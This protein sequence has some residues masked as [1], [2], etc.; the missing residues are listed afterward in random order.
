MEN[1][2]EKRLASAGEV[3]QRLN[4]WTQS[5]TLLPATTIAKSA[6]SDPP[7]PTYTEY[8]MTDTHGDLDSAAEIGSQ[9]NDQYSQVTY[10]VADQSTDASQIH[11]HPLPSWE[12]PNLPAQ[13]RLALALAIAIPA[14][15]FVGMLIGKL[16]FD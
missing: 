15:L 16:L 6:W 9:A 4:A 5:E 1:Y 7:V 3:A 8:G 13:R 14:S 11:A 12:A 2:P 10:A